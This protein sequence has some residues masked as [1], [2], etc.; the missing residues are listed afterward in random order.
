MSTFSLQR[1][2]YA[3]KAVSCC[4]SYFGNQPRLMVRAN[5]RPR[6]SGDPPCSQGWYPHL[7]RIQGPVSSASP[8]RRAIFSWPSLE[9]A[10]DCPSCH[11]HPVLYLTILSTNL[12]SSLFHN[13]LP[14]LGLPELNDRYVKC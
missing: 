1:R 4:C 6:S 3:S 5:Y 9:K 7:A 2:K 12:I 13:I 10:L 14:L 11:W 8:A